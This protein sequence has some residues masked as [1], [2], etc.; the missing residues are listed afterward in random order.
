MSSILLAAGCYL[1]APY[2]NA[3]R[4][5]CYF[6]VMLH[7]RFISALFAFGRV[8]TDGREVV[9]GWIRHQCPVVCQP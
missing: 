9:P 6:G 3:G 1:N 4:G 2:L 8:S 7:F 5:V